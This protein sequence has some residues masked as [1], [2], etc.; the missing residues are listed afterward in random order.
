MHLSDKDTVLASA[1][2]R[3]HE[4]LLMAG[5]PHRILTADADER[6][7]SY[8]KGSPEAYVAAIARLKNH[9]VR[10]SPEIRHNSV[11]ISADTA[12]YLPSS[13]KILGKPNDREDAISM[14][15][16]LSGRMHRV[17]TAVH[18]FDTESGRES[19]FVESTDVYFRPLLRREI[20][21]YI[22]SSRPY[23]KAGAYGIQE[24][25]SVF[26]ARIDGDYFNIVGLPVCR[27]YTT[28]MNLQTIS[29]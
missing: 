11:V 22:D 13:E 16:S 10:H 3:R 25:A 20:E 17:L 7:I 12:V 15:E 24:G 29:L 19:A 18:V 28:L 6:S 14:L 1:S 23:D 26:V 4:L 5:I 21:H 2:P 9:A 27:L 8:E